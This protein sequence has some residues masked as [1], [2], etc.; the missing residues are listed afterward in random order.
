M[1]IVF[2][3]TPDFAV[4]SL[5]KL[6]DSDNTVS[7][8]FTQPDKPVGRKHVLTAPPVKELALKY[9]IPVYQPA[10]LKSDEVYSILKE[11]APELIVVVAYGK[12]LPK[13][14]LD[15]PKNG[16]INVHGSLLP[17]YRGAAPIQWCVINGEK[18]TGV[19]TMFMSEGLDTGDILLKKETEI[20]ENETAAELFD[21]LAPMGA[22]LLIDTIENLKN[23]T[24]I[25]QEDALSNYA[26]IID[27]RI[28]PID[29]SKSAQAVHNQVRGLAGWPVAVTYI[30]GKKVKIHSGKISG[31]TNRNFGEVCDNNK[32]IKVAC[33][34]GLSY[35]IT[36][37]Q[38]DGKK[39]M[40]TA[41]FLLGNKIMIGQKLG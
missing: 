22:E 7:A 29:W 38:F 35:E 34:D 11:L 9:G 31:E 21:R 14:I 37:L 4:P 24:P 2:M 1:N 3:G 16:C 39:R 17:K 20:G 33:G 28:C 10:S 13:R 19:T 40:D 27:K 36:S 15:L 32:C 18:V 23:I 8:V 5:Q 26:P 12:I 25:K 6:I 41:S 30:D